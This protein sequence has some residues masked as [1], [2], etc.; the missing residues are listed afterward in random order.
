MK[1]KI[2]VMMI[3]GSFLFAGMLIQTGPAFA[4]P[5]KTGEG[6]ITLNIAV[7]NMRTVL[8]NIPEWEQF[9]RRHQAKREQAEEIIKNYENRLSVLEMEYEN[10]PPGSPEAEEKR[11]EFESLLREYHQN[12]QEL[13]GT[14]QSHWV[15]GF[16]KFFVE[17][18]DVVSEYARDN[19]IDLVLKKQQVDLSEATP[20]ELETYEASDVLY[21]APQLDISEDII[22]LLTE[23]YADS[24]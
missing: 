16:R 19:E 9:H 6:D 24:D 5:G 14:I 2:L 20:Q 23:R 17:L 10:L 13:S 18:N 4:N 11:E 7:V 1:A 3:A 22:T 12:Q 8:Q 15:E 21:A